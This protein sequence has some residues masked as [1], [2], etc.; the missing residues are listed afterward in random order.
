[1]QSSAFLISTWYLFEHVCALFTVL[2]ACTW[3]YYN[4]F[5]TEAICI[6]IIFVGW[7]LFVSW[8]IHTLLALGL[9]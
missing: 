3:L 7:F 4:V 1:M 9:D 2:Y 5:V 8:T 6:A